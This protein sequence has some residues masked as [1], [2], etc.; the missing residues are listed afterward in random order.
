[1]HTLAPLLIAQTRYRIIEES[2]PRIHKCL[3]LLNTQEIWLKHNNH[4]NSIGNLILHLCGNVRQ[5]IMSGLDQQK[6]RR[7][8]DLEFSERGPIAK[9]VLID[10]LNNLVHDLDQSLNRISHIDL[11]QVR[12]VQSVFTE[13]GV[14]IL[15][16]VIEHF[17]YH[18]GQITYITKLIK[19]VDTGYYENVEL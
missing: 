15:V 6:D 14:S 4:T 7:E 18:V 3:S 10:M 16:H 9:S 13:D 17:S 2:I 5:W 12:T 11:T 8:R 1:M 19:N